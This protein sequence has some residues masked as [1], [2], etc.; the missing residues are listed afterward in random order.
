MPNSLLVLLT[1]LYDENAHMD[2]STGPTTVLIGLVSFVGGRRSVRR[3][4]DSD[5]DVVARHEYAVRH[6]AAHQ[7]PD[8]LVA[9]LYGFDGDLL[10]DHADI[11]AGYGAAWFRHVGTGTTPRAARG[12]IDVD[13]VVGTPSRIGATLVYD[14]FVH[15]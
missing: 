4:V 3:L 5:H 11:R 2:T 10:A 13:V 6:Y 12:G 8:V 15:V 7:T 1:R 14:V 9:D